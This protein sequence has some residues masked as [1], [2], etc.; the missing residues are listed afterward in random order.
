[1][2]CFFG[3]MPL[4][5]SPSPKGHLMR[6][7]DLTVVSINKYAR[8]SCTCAMFN[9]EAQDYPDVSTGVTQG[10][11]NYHNGMWRAD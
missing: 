10:H 4:V 8:N 2:V 7:Q 1:M 6:D 5:K 9:N 3:G 11:W